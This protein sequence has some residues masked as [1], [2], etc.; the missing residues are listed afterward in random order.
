MRIIVR[1]AAWFLLCALAAFAED[2]RKPGVTCWSYQHE[3]VLGT[4]L[5]LKIATPFEAD[6]GKAESAALAEVDRLSRIL[7][8][9]DADSE[10]SRWLKG[11]QIPVVISTE[12]YDV[13]ALFDHWRSTTGGALDASAEVGSRLWR[14]AAAQGRMPTQDELAA[15]AQEMRGTHWRL[16]GTNRSAVRLS[17]APLVL[18]SFTKIHIA[19]CVA[20]LLLGGGKVAGVVVNLGGDIVVRGEAT[21]SVSIANPLADSENGEPIAR[22]RVRNRAVATSGSYRRGVEIGGRWYSHI[23]DPRTAQA[24]DHVVSATVVA[25]NAS[26]AGALATASCVL[27]PTESLRLVAS[28]PDAECLLVTKA[29]QTITSPGWS[30]WEEPRIHLAAAGEVN[31]LVGAVRRTDV[32]RWEAEME[33]LVNLEVARIDGQRARRPFVAVWVE[34]QDKFPVRTLALWHNNQRWLPDLKS[35]YRG[36][37]LRALADGTEIARTVSSATRSPGKYTL[38]WDGKDDGGK[39]VKAGKYTILI[40]AAREHGTYQLIRQE[41]EFNGTPRQIQLKGNVEVASVSL[42]YRKKPDGR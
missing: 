3:N 5:D 14:S 16:D 31:G 23:I 40:E 2:S 28:L 1:A 42:D 20:D 27:N 19:G 36:D 25:R 11:P 26:D 21:E 7:S 4:S 33:L 34:D 6:A 30:R 10:F 29:G 24:V 8:A 15:A 18:N 17:R 41:M 35:W 9:Y 22:L 12:L 32:G 37:R 39:P 38:K 13:L